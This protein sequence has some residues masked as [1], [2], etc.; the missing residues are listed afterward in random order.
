MADTTAIIKAINDMHK[1]FDLSLKEVYTE[2]KGC[3]SRVNEIEK[4]LE[5]KRALCKKKKEDDKKDQAK[6]KETRTFW[7][8][9]LR[10]ISVAGILALCALV[11]KGMVALWKM[12][13]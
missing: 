4:A 3:N 1:A 13:P 12:L 7:R 2:I 10:T 5:V 6:A 9:I 8:S 11:W